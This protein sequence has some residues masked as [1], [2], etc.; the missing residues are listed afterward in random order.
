[1]KKDFHPKTFLTCFVDI[2]SGKRYF[3]RST[4]K[5]KKTEVIDGIEY[6]IDIR[7][8]TGDT[9]PAYT[10]EKRLVDTAG[11]IDKFQKKFI[12]KRG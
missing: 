11:R 4:R 10:G 3:N 5:G 12:R 9:H 8:I 1:M 2:S 6:Q 7:D